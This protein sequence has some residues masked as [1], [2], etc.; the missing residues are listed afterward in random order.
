MSKINIEL[1]IVQETLLITLWARAIEATHADPILKDLKSAAIL[2]QINYDFSK[3]K[4]ARGSQV[5]ICLRGAEFD[6]WVRSFLDKHPDGTIVEIGSGLNT[7]F[8]RVDNGRVQWFDLDLLD[9]ISL[10]QQFFAESS[11]RTFLAASVLDSDWIAVVKSTGTHPILFVAEGVLMY[12]SEE[13]VKQVFKLLVDHFPGCLF[14]F[15]SMSPFM[16]KHQKHHDVMKHYAARFQWG[17]Q[18]IHTIQTWDSRY[19]VLEVNSFSHLS[20]KYTRRM[21]WIN[22]ILLRIPP[23]KNSYR[24]SLVKLG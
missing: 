9:S 23:M 19:Q 18:D 7:R 22:N 14:A 21:G 16:V 1:G 5:G 10:R 15:D 11:H 4:T 17:I 12:F 3:L 6:R 24:L 20:A 2:E 13:Q 8:E